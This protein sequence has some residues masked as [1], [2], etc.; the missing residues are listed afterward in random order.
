MGGAVCT[1]LSTRAR[2]GDLTHMS[3]IT[4]NRFP[5]KKRTLSG[6]EHG[7]NADSGGFLGGQGT[8]R[9]MSRQGGKR[10]KRW[11]Y[12]SRLKPKN[13]TSNHALERC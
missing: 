7:P 3:E 10:E 2:L 12:L 11:S 8:P 9:P 5:K 4:I 13:F 1:Y 6:L